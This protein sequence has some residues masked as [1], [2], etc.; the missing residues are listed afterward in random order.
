MFMYCGSLFRR[1]EKT[2]T[3]TKKTH[4]K[5]RVKTPSKERKK[6]PT[7]GRVITP[8]KESKEMCTSVL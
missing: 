6:I 2:R 5:E 1:R 3:M 4:I 7:K 8:T